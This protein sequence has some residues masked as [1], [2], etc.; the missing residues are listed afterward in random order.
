V[1]HGRLDGVGTDTAFQAVGGYAGTE[2]RVATSRRIGN[3]WIG[4]FVRYDS[5]AGAA[6]VDSPLV[7]SRSYWA[8]GFGFA[9]MIAKSQHQ[10]SGDN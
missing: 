10:V 6:F 7:R 8:A 1:A 3:Y 4:G 5:L 9:R 2:L